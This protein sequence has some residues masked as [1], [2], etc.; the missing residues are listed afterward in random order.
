MLVNNLIEMATAHAEVGLLQ[1]MHE[2][3]LLKG[4]NLEMT[5]RG[6]EVCQYCRSD[7]KAIIKASGAR[8]RTIHEEAI[9]QTRYWESGM[10]KWRIEKWEK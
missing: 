10:G 3:G 1:Q 9:G 2:A 7:I 4:A 6:L 8:S 5:V